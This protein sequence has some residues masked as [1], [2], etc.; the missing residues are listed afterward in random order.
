MEITNAKTIAKVIKDI[1]SRINISLSKCHS[2]CYDRCSTTKGQK[3]GV[4]KQIKDIKEKAL[5]THC[6]THVLH[7][8][9][10]DAIKNSEIM[11]EGL[12]TTHEIFK[13]IKKSPKRDAKF[14]AIKN[15]AK[16]ISNSKEDH[17]EA[18][19]FVVSNLLDCSYKILE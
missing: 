13:L 5:F 15:E 16:I 8:A 14:D 3:A 11:K 6:Y 2:Q 18:I 1:L 12:E 9:V 7:L 4:A 19:T 17:T 10:G